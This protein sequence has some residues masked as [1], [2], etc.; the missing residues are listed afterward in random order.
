SQLISIYR[1][2]RQYPTLF[3]FSSRRRHTRFS[4]DWSSDV[5]SSDLISRLGFIKAPTCRLKLLRRGRDWFSPLAPTRTLNPLVRNSNLFLEDLRRLNQLKD[6]PY[7]SD[8]PVKNVNQFKPK[9]S[10]EIDLTKTCL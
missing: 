2:P 4:R 8:I 7:Q 10:H 3:F 1:S 6:S 9:Q 5:C